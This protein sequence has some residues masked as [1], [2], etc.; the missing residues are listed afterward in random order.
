LE[1]CGSG[2]PKPVLMMKN[3]SVERAQCVGGGKHL[4]LRLRRGYHSF[5]AIYFSCGQEVSAAIQG[6]TVDIAFVPQINEYRDE[7]TV[8]MNVLDLRPACN[9]ECDPETGHYRALLE[10]N[11]SRE[12]AALLLPDRA[13]LGTV[14]RY[15][16]AAAEH[17]ESPM[18]LLRKIVRWSGAPMSL[19]K[20]LVCLDIFSDVALLE[21]HRQQKHL[22]IRVA[23]PQQK[24]DLN[25]SA[26]MQRLNAMKE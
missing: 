20:L 19:E 7:R 8:Q 6:E 13:T 22:V 5:N 9:A 14:W 25:Q 23:N 26:T 11:C 12:A 4:R 17:R 24:A 3:L 21:V 15:L 1:P 18:C 10:G 2:C 16:S